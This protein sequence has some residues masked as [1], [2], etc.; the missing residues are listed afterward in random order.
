VK[1]DFVLIKLPPAVVQAVRDLIQS[2]DDTTPDAYEQLKG[3]LVG[4]F[5]QSMWQQANAIIDH[6]GVGDTRPSALM[7]SMLS[8]LPE[9][10]RPGILFLAHFL[11]RLP[12]EIRNHL[13]GAKFDS[14]RDMAAHAD[15]LW[16]AWGG[17]A[18]MAHVDYSSSRGR[19]P[20]RRDRGQSPA[21]KS[22]G[23]GSRSGQGQQTP[24]RKE[25]LCFYHKR[26]GARAYACRA[27]CTWA[28]NEKAA[29]SN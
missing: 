24:G 18:M 15:V 5:G 29:S 13:A 11:R 9:G 17:A 26:F 8:L 10:E 2:V 21:K 7:N 14:P 20:Q 12:A 16:D 4:S 6:P 25:K 28:G 22:P 27:P 1:Y 23:R 19:S 3:R